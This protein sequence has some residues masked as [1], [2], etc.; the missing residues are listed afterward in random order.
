MKLFL[1]EIL[2]I[3]VSTRP[4]VLVK[5]LTIEEVEDRSCYCFL[6]I[7]RNIIGPTLQEMFLYC[8]K[9]NHDKTI[10]PYKRKL[11]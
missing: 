5:I 9:P 7:L 10:L 1:K 11:E 6:V 3:Q 2:I 8:P 4:L